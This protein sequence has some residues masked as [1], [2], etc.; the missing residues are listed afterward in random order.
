MHYPLINR[1][2]ATLLGA[3]LGEVL[4]KD[5]EQQYHICSD[6]SSIGVIGTKSLIELGKLDINNWLERHQKKY[7]KKSLHL[8]TTDG[9]LPKAIIATLPVALFFHENTTKLRQ[10]LLDVWQIWNYDPIIRDT[11]LAVGYA[12]AKS[13][14][15]TLVPQTLIPEIITFIGDTNTLI[16]QKLLQVNDLLAQ[17]LGLETAQTVFSP[18]DQPKSAVALAFYCFLSTL[19]DFSLAVLRATQ[20]NCPTSSIITGALSGAYNST[21]GIPIKWQVLL[22]LDNLARWESTSLFQMLEL[23]DALVAVWSGVYDPTLHCQE[24]QQPQLCVFASPRVIQ[25]R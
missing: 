16:P 9:V 5:A 2:K 14:T 18:E 21:V 7:L 25:W 20:L 22:R 23:A 3:L 15:E 1:Y 13:F 4:A 17:G 19:E 10:N 8:D 24:D 11:T 6:I 12:I